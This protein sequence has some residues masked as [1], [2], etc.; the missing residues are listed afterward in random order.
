MITSSFDQTTNDDYL[1]LSSGFLLPRNYREFF[2]ESYVSRDIIKENNFSDSKSLCV[3]YKNNIEELYVKSINDMDSV[4]NLLYSTLNVYAEIFKIINLEDFIKFQCCY[5]E[6]QQQLRLTILKEII[7]I[8]KTGVYKDLSLLYNLLNR[9]K[10]LSFNYIK[11]N[12]IEMENNIK[13]I[14]FYSLKNI[15]AKDFFIRSL[16]VVDSMNNQKGLVFTLSW[17]NYIF[18]K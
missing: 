10:D 7:K 15:C 8:I 12:D 2:K 4:S 9:H 18:S 3:Y 11:L 1:V 14:N 5:K 16:S 17:L 6:T 13:Y